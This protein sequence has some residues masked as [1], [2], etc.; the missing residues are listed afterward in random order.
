MRDPM[1]EKRLKEAFDLYRKDWERVF[2]T[3]IEESIS[4]SDNLDQKVLEAIR[5]Q[6]KPRRLRMNTWQRMAACF[7]VVAVMGTVIYFVANE[8]K[9][10]WWDISKNHSN[11]QG[12][13]SPQQGVAESEESQ[14]PV[15]FEGEL[16]LP[17]NIPEGFG[18]EEVMGLDTY[19]HH[20]YK[21]AAGQY[22]SIYQIYT[23]AAHPLELNEQYCKTVQITEEIEGIH[24]YD[25][26]VSELIFEYNEYTFVISGDFYLEDFI[27]F[28]RSILK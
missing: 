9:G 5:E 12:E 21:N 17:D 24:H 28:A 7:A 18:Q 10:G 20:T 6:K 8:G 19:I 13:A 15:N 22:L 1:E 26:V 3:E 16:M 27:E 25:G 4:I 14:C 2:L 11:M 23:D